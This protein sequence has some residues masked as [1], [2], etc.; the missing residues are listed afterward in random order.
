MPWVR[1][2]DFQAL[3][4]RVLARPALLWK[5]IR[6]ALLLLAFVGVLLSA[7]PCLPG[8]AWWMRYP[9]FPRLQ[10]LL[11]MLVIALLLALVPHRGR[12]VRL[13]ITSLT[14]VSLLSAAL[15]APYLIPYLSDRGLSWPPQVP[16]VVSCPAGDRLRVFEANVQMTNGLDH[17]LLS[18]VRKA[19]PDIAWFQETNAAWEQEL[20]PL[21]DTMPFNIAQAR[22]NYFGIHLFSRLPLKQ[23]AIRNL[24]K[25]RNPSVF[26]S[27]AL[28]SGHEFRLYAIHPRP[29]QVGQGTAERD[30]QLM[31]TALAARDDAIPHVIVG[32]LNAVP[33]EG[34]IDRA[35]QIADVLDPRIGRGLFI[36]WNANRWLLKWPLDHILPGPGFAL[37]RLQVLPA[38][39]SDHL[40][41]LADLC[42]INSSPRRASLA[43][44]MLDSA[45]AAVGHGQGKADASGAAVSPGAEAGSEEKDD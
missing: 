23:T 7:L 4:R 17:R 16:S 35:L 40:P 43:N 37:L 34:V 12:I 28:P 8:N 5:P 18:L 31:A 41:L 6:L 32:D 3:A 19:Q 15:L 45:R 2:R 30:A 22:E 33:W 14:V 10:I 38:F 36:T 24:T 29:P 26:T 44:A 21:K 13:A 25:S 42:L 39:G 27:A 20:A 11:A 1:I 9:A